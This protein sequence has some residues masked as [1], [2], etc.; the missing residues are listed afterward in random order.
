MNEPF[1]S[2][3][4]EDLPIS[5]IFI[6]F[7]ARWLDKQPFAGESWFDQI[8][9]TLSNPGAAMRR[10]ARLRLE[11]L[12]LDETAQDAISRVYRWFC[13][14]G[15]AG[16]SAL[17]DFHKRY[18]F[19]LIVGLGRTGGSY[20][21]GELYSALGFDPRLVPA[22]IAHDG[23]PEAQPL[24][25]NRAGNP[26]ITNLLSLSEYLTM[27]EMYFRSNTTDVPIKVP[28]KLT[29]GVYSGGLFNSVFG[30]S[31]EYVITIRHPIASCVSTYEK[32]GG[33]P[34]DGFAKSRSNI[35]VW[36]KR[37]LML[38]GVRAAEVDGMDY[39]ASY[40][41]Y[42]EQYYIN[43]VMSGLSANR[44]RVVI[45]YGKTYMEEAARSWHVRFGSD[46]QHSLFLSPGGMNQRYPQWLKRSQEAIERVAAVWQLMDLPFPLDEIGQCL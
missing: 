16:A 4:S 8:S 32:S 34:S 14:L 41:R 27:I 33:F 12:L 39:F 23:F 21:T 17:E 38:A 13:D 15:A 9:E 28:K 10:T 2:L 1:A 44:L 6:D 11:R 29:K 5:P 37:D 42:W 30:D 46:R 3:T 35:E 26:L 18:Q 45:P 40:V 19:I 25:L 31:A 22:V 43:L 7:L 24:A 36:I 20:L